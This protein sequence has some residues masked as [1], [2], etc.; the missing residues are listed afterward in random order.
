MSLFEKLFIQYNQKSDNKVLVDDKIKSIKSNLHIDS[1]FPMLFV[2]LLNDFVVNEPQYYFNK[3]VEKEVFNNLNTFY[4][5]DNVR[6]INAFSEQQQNLFHAINSYYHILDSYNEFNDIDFNDE[7][8]IKMYYLPTITQLM[9]FCLHHFYRTILYITDDFV[10]GE[11]KKQTKLNPINEALTKLGYVHLT[12]IN[13]DLRNA[14]SHGLVEI[15]RNP[16][17]NFEVVYSYKDKKTHKHNSKT[18]TINDLNNIVNQLFDVAS[19]T[20]VGI[21]KLIIKNKLIE[22]IDIEKK[23]IN[24]QFEFFK[25]FLHNENIRVKSISKSDS[26]FT[27]LKINIDIKN[28]DDTNQIIHILVWIGKILFA[29]WNN[30][31]RY[32]IKYNH[33]FSIGGSIIFDKKHLNEILLEEDI[34]K[35]DNIFV[36]GVSILTPDIQDMKLDSR[37]YKYHTFPKLYGKNWEIKSIKDI[38]IENYK[39]L[40]ASLFIESKD[41]SKSE[42]QNIIFQVEKKVRVLENKSNPKTKIKYGKIEVDIVRLKIFY[43]SKTRNKNSS[44]LSNNKEFICLAH[45]YKGK[46]IPKLEVLFQNNYIFENIKKLDIYWNKSL[47]IKGLINENTI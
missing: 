11:Y 20:F 14:I 1:D 47:D 3:V 18:L 46:T 2:G 30:Y 24:I 13:I 40:E 44:L 9:E 26:D 42:L 7:I 28:I 33:P 8:K 37:S 35:I 17:D 16:N 6:F 15:N 21:V 27:Q 19:G 10:D 34:S 43:N 22:K 36:N 32:E 31:D 12:N 29:T 45:Y 25:L 39:R 5:D 4:N 41:I 38:S 23:D